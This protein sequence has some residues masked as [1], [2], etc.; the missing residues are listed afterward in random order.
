MSRLS[1]LALLVNPVNYSNNLHIVEMESAKQRIRAAAARQKAEKQAQEAGG[2][3][4]STP[5]VPTGQA[6]RKPDGSDRRPAKK[7]AVTPGSLKE[8]SPSKPSHGVGKGLMT[9]Q[10]PVIEGPSRLLTHKDYAVEEARSFVKPADIEP[11]E[12]LE[13]EDLGASAL[14]DLTRVGLLPLLR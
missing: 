2:E 5:K 4:S 12:Q 11:C 9:S 1:S 13:T 8:K 10:G 3:A 6:K 7:A 14:F